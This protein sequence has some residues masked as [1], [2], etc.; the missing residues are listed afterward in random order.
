[1]PASRRNPD[2]L[3]TN[4]LSCSTPVRPRHFDMTAVLSPARRANRKHPSSRNRI[5]PLAISLLRLTSVAAV[6]GAL[7]AGV[8]SAKAATFYWDADGN[9]TGNS[10]DGTG[11]GGT[12]FWDN[13]APNSTWWNGLSAD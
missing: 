9:A 3:M 4:S 11:L 8:R 13:T 5:R 2:L 10:L 7:L 1:M 6:C 12:G